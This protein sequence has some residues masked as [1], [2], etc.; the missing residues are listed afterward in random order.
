[1]TTKAQAELA[2][3]VRS[4]RQVWRDLV[5]AAGD[6]TEE[7]GAMGEWTFGDLAGHLAGWRNRRCAM[8]EAAGRGE[9]VPPDPWSAEISDDED[10]EA[11]NVWIR[12]HD[13]DR[14]AAELIADFDAS[15]E[16]LA[17]AIEA[18]PEG[19]VEDPAAFAWS[20]GMALKDV[21]LNGHLNDEHLDE[22][23]AWLAR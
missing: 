19:M 5:A 6:R 9:P 3:R 7:P 14:S 1:M 17:A 12:E 4:D 16:R 8:L 15:Y 22:V 21:D 13:R 2:A 23:R 18:L 20:D 10:I 11:I